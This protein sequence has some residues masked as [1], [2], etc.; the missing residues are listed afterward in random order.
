MKDLRRSSSPPERP[1]IPT[2][3]LVVN[4]KLP[5]TI[6]PLPPKR[7][8][9]WDWKLFWSPQVPRRRSRRSPSALSDTKRDQSPTNNIKNGNSNS[10]LFSLRLEQRSLSLQSLLEEG[11]KNFRSRSKSRVNENSQQEQII[12]KDNKK[13]PK[14]PKRI[15]KTVRTTYT[16]CP[17]YIV[18]QGLQLLI[19]PLTL[20]HP[21][22]L[23]QCMAYRH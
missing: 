6:P 8:E 10:S 19:S 20:G 23:I 12:L 1:P 3:A 21:G 2:M 17:K 11:R 5:V 22:Q 13:P 4:S 14:S 15:K 16:G 7:S 9:S 18:F